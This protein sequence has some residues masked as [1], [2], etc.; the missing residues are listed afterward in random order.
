MPP[1]E[2]RWV[3]DVTYYLCSRTYGDTWHPLAVEVENEVEGFL[4]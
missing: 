1:H 3:A 4:M 2:R